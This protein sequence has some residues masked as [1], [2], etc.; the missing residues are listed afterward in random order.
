MQTI[1]NPFPWIP[2]DTLK[3]PADD[4][5]LR[6]VNDWVG[7]IDQ[8]MEFVTDRSVA[9]QAGGACGIWP[10]RLACDFEQVYTAEPN[11]DNYAVLKKNI[12]AFHNISHCRA[13]LGDKQ[14]FGSLKRDAFEDG[15]AGAWYLSEGKDFP[16]VTIDSMF[17]DSCGLIMLDV[18]GFELEALRGA[19]KTLKEFN[20]V[21][22]VEAKQL[23]HMDKSA[24][25]AG[26][27]LESLG[28]KQVAKF[29]NDVVFKC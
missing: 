25:A 5:K 9:V 26:K 15:N 13:G 27:Y 6:L 12:R 29:H 24:N 1:H 23:P 10:A 4:K 21:V 17:L 11:Q 2:G 3:W 16:I 14:G 28:Y 18:E 22:V 8:I 7:D 19:E 20:P